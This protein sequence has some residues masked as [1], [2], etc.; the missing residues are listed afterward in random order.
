MAPSKGQSRFQADFKSATEKTYNNITCLDKGDVEDEITF[1]FTHSSLPSPSQF[2][3]RVQPQ[4]IR[5]Y[6]NESTFLVYTNNDIPSAVAR[7]LEESISKTMGMRIDNMLSNLSQRLRATL[8]NDSP[9]TD[10]A[11]MTDA[12]ADADESDFEMEDM[13][14]S[15]ED[16]PFDYGDIV[17]TPSKQP[18]PPSITPLSGELLE[19]LRR[20]LLS[21]Y[22][23][24]AGFHPCKIG[25]FGEGELYNIISVSIRIRKLC[26]SQ[27]TLEAWYLDPSDYLVLLIR[28][29]GGYHTFE[30]LMSRPVGDSRTSFRLR[31][32]SK[33]R[34]T[35]EE[36]NAAF[37]SNP[38]EKASKEA[39][40]GPELSDIWISKSI[41]DLLNTKFIAASKLRDSDKD[42]SWELAK[43][44][45]HSQIHQTRMEP[46]ESPQIEESQHEVGKEDPAT[47]EQ[48]YEAKLPS[49]LTVD[50]LSGDGEVSLPLVAMQFALLHLVRCT[51]YCVVCHGKVK[52]NFEALRPYVCSESLCL[53]Q[54]M[55]V[56]LG[57]SIEYEIVNQ[58]NV[59]DLLISFCYATLYAQ[60]AV[61]RWPAPSTQPSIREFPTGLGLKVPKIRKGSAP[62][63][64]YPIYGPPSANIR[65]PPVR[66]I[67]E[68][69]VDPVK[70][71][72]HWSK[73]IAIITEQSSVNLQEGQWV[74]I[75]TT[76][77]DA[78]WGLAVLHHARIE[79]M[80][81]KLLHLS[82][83]S[84]HS[85]PR[86][87]EPL[88]TSPIITDVETLRGSI[89]NDATVPGYIVTC[90]DELDDLISEDEKAF[91]IMLILA[92]LPSVAEMRSYLMDNQHQQLTLAKWDRM[93]K[94]SVNLL[95]WI[96]AS[97]RSYI[98]QVGD[99]QTGTQNREKISGVDGWV[100]FRF[101]QGSPEKEE[102]FHRALQSVNKPTKTL[103]AWHG[104]GL[105]NWHSIIRQGLD[106]KDVA[107]G[108]SYGNGI[109]F[110]SSF[111]Y[112][113]SYTRDLDSNAKVWP[114][115][116]L[117]IGAAISLNELV[118]L[119]E[120]FVC[121][122]PFVV[123]ECHWTQCRYLFVK[124]LPE[125]DGPTR[126][127]H[128]PTRDV[129]ISHH[130]THKTGKRARLKKAKE[131][132][133]E[134]IQDPTYIAQGPY[135]AK[136]FVPR[137]AIPSARNEDDKAMNSAKSN[138]SECESDS[139]DEDEEDFMFLY[140]AHKTDFRP[141]TLDFSTLPQLAAPSYATN[142]AQKALQQEITKLKKIQDSTPLHQLGWYIDFDRI[143]NLS[144]WIVELHSF[145]PD[146]P[147]AQDMKKAGLTSIV[148]E[149]RF[150][151]G[152]PISPP[153]VRVVRPRFL[154]FLNGGGGHV[155]GGGA[156]CME[157]LT[158]S[159]WSPANSLE[160]VLLQV[161]MA[162][163]STDPP[164]RLDR[165]VHA[166]R[167]YGVREA[168]EAY[169][170]AA[171]GH[172]WEVPPD[173]LDESLR[174]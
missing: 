13:D 141:G 97:N 79:S 155:T 132:V 174:S 75:T 101:A 63:V 52:G 45:V 58:P 118:N 3:I 27:E 167:H 71:D 55:N 104:S 124:P 149:M 92:G 31:K 165:T 2:E 85:M 62:E 16:I 134:F 146:L 106:F 168:V 78:P 164:A 65:R 166:L 144:Q 115:S 139:S 95:R 126:D 82:V 113:A 50:H 37:A 142:I 8:E 14:S 21:V 147:L 128:G 9:S 59:V 143:E 83:A 11:A 47:G 5:G 109:Y 4:D 116:S 60:C 12:D 42:I 18:T 173:F 156:M 131:E 148:L 152:F 68:K 129:P 154:P 138:T 25:G 69:L 172:G 74:A 64:E 135:G 169:K 98:V 91:S 61:S 39:M 86:F 136:L 35:Q 162:I 94:E 46:G 15:D 122:Q 70:I 107:H 121:S 41:D 171:M 110:S 96:I 26:L 29:E 158:N 17:P 93:S 99:G 163:C 87:Y 48:D 30:D 160:S 112:S 127:V 77:P 36:A 56:G 123:Q 103:L 125:V 54:Y 170:R 81:G 40:E 51:D 137:Y 72:F 32:C 22:E 114:R 20:D 66:Y 140:P 10:D 150:L 100:Q 102:L 38:P 19:R 73:S 80:T 133:R 33:K 119:P 130:K 34:T 7:V 76:Q 157:L 145:D 159:G 53:H 44:K 120:K 1:I 49:F 90:D 84:R 43:E 67:K 89:G 28:Y 161:R 24:E 111:D 6:P 151:R 23:A 117:K 108:R 88:S 153:F 105:Y 57:P